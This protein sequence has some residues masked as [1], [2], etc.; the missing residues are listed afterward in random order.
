M[1][2]TGLRQWA[3]ATLLGVWIVASTAHAG[4]GRHDRPKERYTEKAKQFP[5]VGSVVGMFTGTL[6]APEWVLTC[7]HGAEIIDRIASSESRRTV[8]LAEKEYGIASVVLHPDRGKKPNRAGQTRGRKEQTKHDIALIRLADPVTNVEPLG[9]YTGGSEVGVE[10]AFVGC[11]S[12]ISDGRV[13]VS[14][15]NARRLKRGELHAGTN[16]IDRIDAFG[17]LVMTFD[18]PEDDATN[19][20]IG[21]GPGDSG[22]PMLIQEHGK[23]KVAGVAAAGDIEPSEGIGLYGDLIYG[24]RVSKYVDWIRSTMR[25][26]SAGK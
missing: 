10:A 13:G 18:A 17:L 7:A 23:W 24:T 2:A 22:G 16:R 15:S 19:L 1:T 14:L 12:W 8:R 5:A 11:G 3:G 6:V 9:L 20:E 4:A 21:V 26:D 25:G